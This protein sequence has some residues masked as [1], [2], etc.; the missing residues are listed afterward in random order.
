MA[1]HSPSL[2]GVTGDWT[3]EVGSVA[4]EYIRL[5]FFYGV[6]WLG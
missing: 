5:T 3:L 6:L 1:F 4:V 2:M